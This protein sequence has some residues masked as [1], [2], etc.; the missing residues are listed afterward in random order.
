MKSGCC[1]IGLAMAALLALVLAPGLAHA[2]EEDA[3]GTFSRLQYSAIGGIMSGVGPQGRTLGR[4][5][6][7]M[8]NV[9]GESTIGMELGLEAAYAASNDN[10]NTTFTSAGLIARLS[11]TPEDYRAYVQLGA[12]IYHVTFSPDLPGIV[13]PENTTRPGGS[14]GLGLELFDRAHFTIGGLV[15]YN[16]VVV[17]HNASRSYLLAGV[18]LTFKP[19]P[20]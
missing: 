13:A 11:P 19:S 16:G 17:A 20:Y 12:S 5:P 4:G 7:V 18:T 8:F 3:T 6:A 2:Q 1:I 10:L 15:T 14:F 9:H